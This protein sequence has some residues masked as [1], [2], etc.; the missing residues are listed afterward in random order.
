MKLFLEVTKF[1]K[2]FCGSSYEIFNI[3]S[4]LSCNAFLNLIET[5]LHFAFDPRQLGKI[6]KQHNIIIIIINL[7]CQAFNISVSSTQLDIF[8]IVRVF[9]T[10]QFDNMLQKCFN[11]TYHGY[12]SLPTRII[13]ISTHW[14]FTF[15]K[16]VISTL[17][18]GVISVPN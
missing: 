12:T 14:T 11:C 15:S 1:K 10:M 9:D 5:V 2:L 18:Q 17:E 16:T 3:G 7:F 13:E 6:S 8:V 4:L